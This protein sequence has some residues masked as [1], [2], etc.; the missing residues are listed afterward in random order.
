MKQARS[1]YTRRHLQRCAA[2]L[3]DRNGFAGAT[4]DDVSRA[5]G[6]T[7]GAFYF[8]F[9][10]KQELGAAIQAEACAMLRSS[11]DKLIVTEA[12]ALQSLIDLTHLLANW[13]DGEPVVRASLRTARE[14]GDRGEPFVDFYTELVATL[15]ATLLRAEQAGELDTGV[16]R[17]VV[18]T[19]VLTMC[20]GIEML[21][22]SGIRGGSA[23]AGLRDM[24]TLMLPGVVAEALIGELYPGGSAAL[25]PDP[26]PAMVPEQQSGDGEP[27]AVRQDAGST[28]S[29]R[30]PSRT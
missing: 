28:L 2:E 1:E 18:S 30:W 14:F 11:V 16:P 22:W 19:M 5:A 17:D 12:H 21:W 9:A 25:E 20:V 23:R 27:D 6:V 8:H 24:W 3:F 7:K 29:G 15:D 13:L 4:L 26:G 10:S